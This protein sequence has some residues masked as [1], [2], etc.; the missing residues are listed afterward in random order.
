MVTIEAI[1]GK[2]QS[3]LQGRLGLQDFTD[4]VEVLA[5]ECARDGSGLNLPENPKTVAD[6]LMTIDLMTSEMYL[7]GRHLTEAEFRAELGLL[8]PPAG[9]GLGVALSLET[10]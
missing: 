7:S 5:D 1:Q 9:A 4:W 3:Y 8:F 2:A 10:R 6:I